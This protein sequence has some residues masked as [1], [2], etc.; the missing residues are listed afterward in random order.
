MEDVRS[1]P[2]LWRFRQ[3]RHAVV[4]CLEDPE[5]YEARRRAA[6]NV[7][8][9]LGEVDAG[10]IHELKDEV[11]LIVVDQ[12]AKGARSRL[13]PSVPPGV[14]LEVRPR[15][16]DDAAVAAASVLARAR[17]LA[18]MDR[19]SERVGFALPRGSSEVIEAGRRVVREA[20]EE[21]LEDVAKTSFG[22]TS[23]I[24]ER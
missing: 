12:Y 24:L 14:R 15:A 8:D 17:Q 21:G 22:L 19:L 3:R 5:E 9:L 7:N 6:G 10:I 13:A 18:E 2:E 16:E 4:V 23:Q 11:E 20:G 1:L